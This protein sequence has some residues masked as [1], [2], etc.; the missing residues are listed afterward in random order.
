MEIFV[1]PKCLQK[2]KRVEAENGDQSERCL[3][4]GERVGT[5]YRTLVTKRESRFFWRDLIL[6]P[7]ASKLLKT[8]KPIV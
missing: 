7:E 4:V 8:V 5:S 6:I 1:K 3:K 2:C